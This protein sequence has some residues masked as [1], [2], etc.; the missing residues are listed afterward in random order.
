MLLEIYEEEY[1]CPICCIIHFYEWLNCE[2]CC[3]NNSGK[4]AWYITK[5]NST[6]SVIYYMGFASGVFHDCFVKKDYVAVCITY[7]EIIG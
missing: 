4:T 3:F 7:L 6:F 1:S 2:D 5:N